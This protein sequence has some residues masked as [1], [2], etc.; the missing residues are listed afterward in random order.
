[1][2]PVGLDH[3]LACRFVPAP[4]TIFEGISKLPPATTLHGRDRLSARRDELPRGARS[5]ADRPRGRGARRRAGR[6]FHRRGGAPDDVRRPLR[7]I[8]E[9]RHGLRRHRRRDGQPLRGAPTTFTIG[10]PGHGEEIDE[11]EAAAGSA[12]IGTDHRDTTTASGRTSWASS[13]VRAQ[14]RGAAGDPVRTRPHAALTVRGAGREGRALGAG[15][16]RAPRRL[17]PPPRGVR[18]RARGEAGSAGRAAARGRRS[19]RAGRAARRARRVLGDMRGG[20]RL[21]RLVEITG[22]PLRAALV[23]AAGEEAAAE[24]TALAE[25]VLSLTWA[26]AALVEQGLYL[27]TH[28]LLPDH[29]LLCADKMSM[30]ASLEQRVPFL[31]VELMRFVERIPRRER[32]RPR[33]GQAPAPQGDGAPAAAARSPTARS[34]ASPAPSTC[35]CGS[36]SAPRSSG[37]TRAAPRWRS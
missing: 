14:S 17:H 35:G 2:D 29:L 33:A 34:T 30:S 5:A 1:M 22:E 8:P 27:D 31:D 36:R 9:R 3:Y 24:R 32:V 15:R 26:T 23:G 37:A 28:L 12:R 16:R 20:E 6:A 7:R 25:D 21:W 13:S 10:F 4:R 19:P 18:A 11:R